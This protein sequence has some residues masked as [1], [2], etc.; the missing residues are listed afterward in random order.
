MILSWGLSG[1]SSDL[2]LAGLAVSEII[3]FSIEAGSQGLQIFSY[4]RTS[5]E[6]TSKD[7]HKLR[8]RNP[9]AQRHV[10]LTKTTSLNF[11]TKISPDR[12]RHEAR[13]PSLELAARQGTTTNKKPWLPTA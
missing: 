4:T 6:P 13:G 7:V 9:E 12:E 11:I 8:P 10:R 5:P 3:N 1:R 2:Q